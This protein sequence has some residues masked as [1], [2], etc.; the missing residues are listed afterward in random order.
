MALIKHDCDSCLELI[1]A[2]CQIWWRWA[3]GIE[4]PCPHCKNK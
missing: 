3:W 4:E 2:K 1:W